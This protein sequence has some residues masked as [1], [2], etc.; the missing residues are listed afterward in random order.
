MLMAVCHSK[1]AGWEKVDDLSTV[2]ELRVKADHLLW[3]E[4]DVRD[5]TEEDIATIGEEFELDRLAVEDAYNTRQR[6]K[7]ETYDTHHF[8]VFHQLD[9]V[10]DH[11]EAV[12]IACFIGDGYVLTIHAG[13]DRSLE[14]AKERWRSSELPKQHPALLLHTLVDVVVDEYQ[15]IADQLEARM[16]EHEEIALADPNAPMQQQL[17]A[18]KQQ[19]SRLRR[20]VL[21]SA[22]LIDWV[23]DP[24]DKRPFSEDT[25]RLFRDV[26]DHLM[27]ITD[28]VRNVDDLA[29]AVL[30]LVDAQHTRALNEVSRKLSAWAAIF[31]IETLIAGIYGMNFELIPNENSIQG[32]Y[33][34]VGLMIVSGIGL[35][36]YFRR[37]GW[38]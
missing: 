2:S 5:L 6:P 33:F 32:F 7:F 35:Y 26:H 21:P 36:V 1:D 11:L 3:A 16:E 20:Y 23:V 12:Q 18:I 17:Y 24:D 14:E 25:A 37:R 19:V 8:A 27:R 28:Q 31:A 30:D 10:D 9:E 34:A 29:Q 13:A 4:A 22:R 38:L 15:R